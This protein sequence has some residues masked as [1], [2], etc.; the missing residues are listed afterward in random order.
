[1]KKNKQEVTSLNEGIF[2]DLY[3]EQL[4]KRLETNPFLSNGMWASAP[5]QEALE[6]FTLCDRF[7][8]NCLIY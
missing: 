1:M 8:I 6:G 7:N 4:E 2:D 5:E 3:L